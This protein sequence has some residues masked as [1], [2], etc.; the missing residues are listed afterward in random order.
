MRWTKAA[1][2]AFCSAFS[3]LSRDLPVCPCTPKNVVSSH[4]AFCDRSV[5][6]RS[7]AVSHLVAH[8]G[9]DGVRAGDVV[10]AELNQGEVRCEQ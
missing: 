4:G 10:I 5:R 8:I 1:A 6:S 3:A 9:E 2:V 7:E